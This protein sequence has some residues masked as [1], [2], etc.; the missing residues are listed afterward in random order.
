MINLAGIFCVIEG[1]QFVRHGKV[2]VC[3][4]C[5]KKVSVA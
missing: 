3:S 4:A 2:L 1:H 5:G